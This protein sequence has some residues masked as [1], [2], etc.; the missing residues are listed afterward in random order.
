MKQ[1]VLLAFS[2]LFCAK[3]FSQT[4]PNLAWLYRSDM[5]IGN[6]VFRIGVQEIYKA[7]EL[8]YVFE[9][10]NAYDEKKNFE[11]SSS[12]FVKGDYLEKLFFIQLKKN[13][14]DLLALRKK[15]DP[16][17][18]N[19]PVESVSKSGKIDLFDQ[20]QI[21]QVLNTPNISDA[22]LDVNLKKLTDIKMD[23]ESEIWL[24][25]QIASLKAVKTDRAQKFQLDLESSGRNFLNAVLDI[26]QK[27]LYEGS[28][29]GTLYVTDKVNLYTF[30]NVTTIKDSSL[31]I[32]EVE[33]KFEAGQIAG[34]IVKGSFLTIKNKVFTFHNRT[35][36]SFSTK[37]DA[38]FDYNIIKSI[39]IFGKEQLIKDHFVR[40]EELLYNDY[41][42]S[43]YTNNFS[44]IDTV[45]T[46][47]PF[48]PGKVIFRERVA[49]ILQARVYSD[50]IGYGSDQPN[51]LVQVEISKMIYLKTNIRNNREKD[52]RCN[53]TTTKLVA[54][55]CN[56]E[57]FVDSMNAKE[58]VLFNRDG[59]RKLHTYEW[60]RYT[61]PLVSVT[62][63]ER[64]D[65]YLDVSLNADSNGI[66]H[67]IDLMQ[68]ANFKAGTQYNILRA[69]RPEFHSN[70][71]WDMSLYMMLTGISNNSIS[72]DTVSG[73]SGDTV[74]FSRNTRNTNALS[75]NFSPV[76]ISWNLY[77]HSYYHFSFDYQ[78]QHIAEYNS[79]LQFSNSEKG[80]GQW[81][82]H[83]GMFGG[84]RTSEYGNGEI[85]VRVMVNL[86]VLNPDQRFYQAQVG[87]SFK[88]FSHKNEFKNRPIFN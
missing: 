57:R 60:F 9:L 79:G 54:C 48:E 11:I 36:I 28:K 69:S 66:V 1:V 62:K 6:E 39:R 2:L 74:F 44:P 67:A 26:L 35:P 46:L 4:D 19:L 72:R 71:I 52:S 80:W 86:N 21:Q 38:S 22:A 50:F 42:L 84:I 59:Y 3:S 51:G 87:Y 15:N 56:I 53:D 45:I 25:M 33:I 65:K 30:N 88:V 31:Y 24:N 47:R 58:K 78:L 64:N 49:D 32:K 10:K 20:Y 61:I 18:I 34:I 12:N 41:S 73:I 17:V 55:I 37:F 85:F 82:H 16:V 13:Y 5:V 27:R 23:S 14:E 8:T 70:F 7:N 29:V 75:F 40:L 63:I 83:L 76:I 81:I 68:Y 43:N 77:P